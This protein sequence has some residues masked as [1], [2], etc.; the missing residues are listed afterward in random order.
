MTA[1]DYRAGLSAGASGVP[2]RLQRLN[3]TP[4]DPELVEVM[5]HK[6]VAVFEEALLDEL[7]ADT[8]AAAG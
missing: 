2:L 4:W 6:G 8:A 1:A 7:I 5:R 3:T